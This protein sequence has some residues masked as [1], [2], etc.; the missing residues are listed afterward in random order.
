ME[1]KYNQK[2]IA[3]KK[4][5]KLT[6]EF[7]EIQE[8]NQK[9]KRNFNIINRVF[10]FVY[11]L[12]IIY[13]IVVIKNTWFSSDELKTATIS[14]GIDLLVIVWT[15]SKKIK[16]QYYKTENVN[17]ETMSK[18]KEELFNHMYKDHVVNVREFCALMCGDTGER[19]DGYTEEDTVNMYAR[20]RFLEYYDL[21]KEEKGHMNDG[22]IKQKIKP[23]LK[24]FSIIVYFC[25]AAVL[26]YILKNETVFVILIGNGTVIFGFIADE[27]VDEGNEFIDKG[28]D[29]KGKQSNIR[30]EII[31]DLQEL[32]LRGQLTDKHITCFEKL[33]ENDKTFNYDENSSI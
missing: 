9:S 16:E 17:N 6:H 31:N 11:F 19:S 12:I 29:I 32:Y 27:I 28:N 25:L 30:E 24:G 15:I 4:C 2:S 3:S 22:K 20:F 23:F 5:E 8:K 33:L 1:K 21:I 13:F 26:Y 10:K 7:K 18:I 14:F